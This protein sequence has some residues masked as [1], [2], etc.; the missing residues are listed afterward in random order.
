MHVPCRMCR[1]SLPTDST[2]V[3]VRTKKTVE[4]LNKVKLQFR[5]GAYLE[6]TVKYISQRLRCLNSHRTWRVCAL[7]PRRHAFIQLG[8]ESASTSP[9]PRPCS[10]EPKSSVLSELRACIGAQ[11]LGVDALHT[12]DERQTHKLL[13]KHALALRSIPIFHPARQARVCARAQRG[14]VEVVCMYI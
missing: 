2:V 6:P 9:G 11:V 1:H 8:H 13:I 14:V 12:R 5:L 10:G 4:I 3:C 7:A